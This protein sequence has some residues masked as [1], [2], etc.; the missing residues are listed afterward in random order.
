MK[1]SV[2]ALDYDGTIAREGKLD[3]NVRSA[4]EQAR[5]RGIVV[6]LVTGRILSDLRRVTGDLDTFDAVVAENG[7]VLSFPGGWTRVLG[8]SPPP[9]FLDELCRQKVRFDMG[10]CVVETD[11]TAA[12]R[13]LA[14][15]QTLE[16]PLVLAFNR[17]RVMLLPQGISKA[18]GLREALGTLRLSLHNCIGI[19]DAENDYQLLNAC[20]IGVAVGWG[21]KSLREVADEV[22]PGKGPEAVADYIRKVIG[23]T[24]LPRSQA[25][26]RRVLLGQ[27]SDGHPLE[28][29]IH[30]RILL[31]AG[32]PRSGKSWVTGLICEQLILQGYCLCIIDPEGDYAPLE[33][34]PNVVRFG[35][36]EPP[37]RLSDVARA[38]RYPDVSVIIDLSQATH[39]EK[40]SYLRALL[41]ML[42]GL[43]RDTGQPHWI[44]VDEAH[45]FLN[46]PDFRQQMDLEL[47]G[48]MLVTYRVS[49]LYPDL[50]KEIES[51]VVTQ[52]TDARE[53]QLLA[54]MYGHPDE[55]SQWASLLNGLTMD[56]AAVLPQVDAPER[57]LR[58]F[59][60]AA[61]LTPHVRHRS[62][63]LEVPMHENHAFVFTCNDTPFGNAARTL[64]EFVT[65][66][67]R[68]PD[69]SLDGHARRGDFSRW[70]AEVF[71]DQ[72]LAAALRKVER[73]ARSGDLANV[74]VALIAPIRE[75]YELTDF[76]RRTR[77]G[78]RPDEASS[79]GTRIGEVISGRPPRSV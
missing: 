48:Y 6:I 56:E 13:L 55:V 20:E 25:A 67:E 63:Y 16:C 10:E 59:I 73:R 50:L 27:A 76:G 68:A 11:A 71:G 72:P 24:S 45:Y 32:D 46:E 65:L 4:I 22:L 17:S 41:P 49:N 5:A 19:G 29:A 69:A 7:A 57:T 51:I 34:L 60:V 35:G 9:A 12:A 3:P 2:L 38:L 58:K 47:G 36:D 1:F 61:R 26:H 30:G 23:R 78:E 40:E 64:K 77:A 54:K 21:S 44:V 42:A 37:P 62:K 43:R 74:R 28:M 52:I 70:I 79:G 53:A 75:R 18:T 31:I 66:L 8:G 15:V 39:S 33:A 14:A